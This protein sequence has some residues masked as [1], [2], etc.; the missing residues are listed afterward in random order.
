MQAWYP[1]QEAGN[2]I[3]DVLLGKAEPGGRL[4]RT[5][6]PVAW[7]MTPPI[8]I[9]QARP[10]TSATGKA[11]MSA[12]AITRR[13]KSRRSSR[14]ASVSPTRNSGFGA[15]TLSAE[16]IGPDETIEASIEVANVGDRAGST[17]AQF[18]IV[19]EQASVSRPDKE[20]KR[21]VKVWLEPGEKRTATTAF[22]MRCLAF[23]DVATRSWKAEAGRF[24]VLVGSSSADIHAQASFAL[25]KTCIDDSPRFSAVK[26]V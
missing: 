18:Y 14:S 23:F 2:S 19:D 25:T 13:R 7:R 21:F 6:P 9:I 15:L 17:V 12:T 8:S 26:P 16:S 22:D 5:F 10:A 20:L 11:F 3:A 4:F 1:G 24:T